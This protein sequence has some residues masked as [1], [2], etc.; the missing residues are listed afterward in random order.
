MALLSSLSN[1]IQAIK[2]GTIQTL[3]AMTDATY[4]GDPAATKLNNEYFNNYVGRYLMALGWGVYT[5]NTL[6]VKS[7]APVDFNGADS[8]IFQTAQEALD[9]IPS[10]GAS[11]PTAINRWTI[12]GDPT[13]DFTSLN[14]AT[15]IAAGT[16]AY[17]SIGAS[18]SNGNL[19]G[20]GDPNTLSVIGGYVG[21]RYYNS[22]NYLWYTCR[23]IGTGNWFIDAGNGRV[24]V[25]TD[26]GG[27]NARTLT[28]APALTSLIVGDVFII[29][30]SV[31]SNNSAMTLAINGLSPVSIKT[32][33][34]SVTTRLKV[35]LSA[36]SILNAQ[37]YYLFYDGTDLLLMNPNILTFGNGCLA[38]TG[39]IAAG[40]NC[41]AGANSAVFGREAYGVDHLNAIVLGANKRSVQGDS[42]HETIVLRKSTTDATPTLMQ[43]AG[44]L[45]I[46]AGAAWSFDI[47]ITAYKFAGTTVGQVAKW[48]VTGLIKNIAG[49]T[50][51]VGTP[52]VAMP[53]GD[54]G[55]ASGNVAVTADDTNDDLSISVTG[56]SSCDINWVATVKITAAG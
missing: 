27:V 45:I 8:L 11:K 33:Q 31:S 25:G 49:T 56:Q 40:F 55:Y 19:S 28:L 6:Y 53:F 13:I 18:G 41:S 14:W 9:A 26:G 42:Q 44:G 54:A 20:A 48:T 36:L 47:T 43:S 5:K 15:H 50:A 23:V 46:P 35:E 51:L 10:T 30:S 4:R 39:S 7:D 52:T 22:V 12:I 21:Q 1:V 24:F 2:N 37:V 29:T 3:I 34:R 32:Q 38:S 16:A 17:I